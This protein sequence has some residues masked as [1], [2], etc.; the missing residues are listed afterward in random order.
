[1]PCG[2]GL[3][4]IKY[5]QHKGHNFHVKG[6][7]AVCSGSDIRLLHE[8]QGKYVYIGIGAVVLGSCQ[9]GQGLCE[10]HLRDTE[11]HLQLNTFN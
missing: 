10:G 11:K 4:N 7:G 2:A 8:I 6:A 5:K 3:H 9:I 1:M